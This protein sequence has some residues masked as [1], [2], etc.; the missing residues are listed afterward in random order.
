MLKCI[1][2][3][4]AICFDTVEDRDLLILAGVATGTLEADV[5]SWL[6]KAEAQENYYLDVNTYNTITD[7][8]SYLPELSGAN[9]GPTD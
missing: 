1:A 8:I 6:Q 5:A 2:N 9:H 7:L 4:Q 3:M